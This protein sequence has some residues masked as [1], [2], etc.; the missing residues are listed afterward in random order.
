MI[1]R[2]IS[3]EQNRKEAEAAGFTPLPADHPLR[4]EGPSITFLSRTRKP[5]S[6]GVGASPGNDTNTEDEDQD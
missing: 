5:S 6:T 1:A 4:F 2:P 3:A